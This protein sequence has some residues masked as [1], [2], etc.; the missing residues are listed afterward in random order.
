[1]A[2]VGF[3][4]REVK[5]LLPIYELVSDCCDGDFKVKSKKTK[6]LPKPNP[7]DPSTENQHRYDQYVSRAIFYNVTKNTYAGLIGQ[8][9]SKEPQIELPTALEILNKNADGSG[10]SLEQ[11]SKES[12]GYLLKGARFGLLSDYPKTNSE[13]SVEEITNGNI[14]PSLKL[15]ESKDIINWRI[16]TEGAEKFYSL[17]VLKER[18]TSFDDGFEFKEQ[19]NYRVLK[20]NNEGYYEV[21]I[22]NSDIDIACLD[23]DYNVPASFTDYKLKPE[24]IYI[25]TDFN[26]NKLKRIPFEFAGSDNNDAIPDIPVLYDIAVL[27]IGHYR[28]SA[29]Y[30]EACYIV[31]QPTPWFSGLTQ[32]W[33]KDNGVIQLGSR[34]AI[35]L[36]VNGSAGLLQVTANSMP[37]EAMKHKEEQFLALGAKLTSPSSG[38]KTATESKINNITE[39]S[40][41][42]TIATNASKA[43]EN[44]LRNCMQFVAQSNSDKI[45]FELNDDFEITKLTPAERAQLL[46][47]W[48]KGAISWPELRANLREGKVDL[49]DDESAKKYIE[50]EAATALADQI[51]LQESNSK[52]PSVGK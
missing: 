51:K 23:S 33:V 3:V 6:Y 17:V 8:I 41:L 12:V 32:E 18:F 7:D 38:Q 26:G 48:M 21:N 40:I 11:L 28:N 10:K 47:E 25:P 50:E 42:S 37:I 2:N 30:E 16:K 15:Y 5:K 1:M 39:T 35:P 29:D 4:R 43:F 46:S 14:R 9:F 36:P 24:N 13:S 22:Y 52:I 45:I 19:Y 31:G 44:A 34:G 20:L 49:Q 27:N